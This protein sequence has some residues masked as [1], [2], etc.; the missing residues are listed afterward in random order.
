MFFFVNDIRYYKNP[1][2]LGCLI[3]CVVMVT[4]WRLFVMQKL[5]VIHSDSNHIYKHYQA[6]LYICRPTKSV[7]GIF[8]C[9]CLYAHK[10]RLTNGSI[11]HLIGSVNC[12]VIG[13]LWR[14]QKAVSFL[15]WDKS[16]SDTRRLSRTPGWRMSRNNHRNLW[17]EWCVSSW[18]PWFGAVCPICYFIHTLYQSCSL[19]DQ[20]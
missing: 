19:S 3:A 7:L 4:S 15:G 16:I 13:Q 8:C 10:S 14:H 2:H 11:G 5:H 20:N 12:H 6:Q 1:Q 17:I 18:R 9:V